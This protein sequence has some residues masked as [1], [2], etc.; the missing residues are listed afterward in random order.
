MV[1]RAAALALVVVPM[2]GGSAAN[3][4][5]GGAG[6][7]LTITTGG[8]T[9]DMAS[10]V[11]PSTH[12]PV[13]FMYAANGA[14]PSA[15]PGCSSSHGGEVTICDAS[16]LSS[17]VI[18][19]TGA[20]T[21]LSY[22]AYAGATPPPLTI[23]YAYPFSNFGVVASFTETPAGL[24]GP[25]NWAPGGPWGLVPAGTTVGAP[26]IINDETPLGAGLNINAGDG[27]AT[28][29]GGDAIGE[30]FT[31]GSGGGT[32]V[33]GSQP[34]TI[35]AQNHVVDHITCNS[36]QDIV[37]ADPEDVI[38][39]T[40]GTLDTGGPP[41]AAITASDSAPLTG[42]NVTF[43]ASGSSDRA[44]TITDYKWDFDG[45]GYH[46][47]TGTTATAPHTY[48]TPGDYTASVKI[49]D[50]GGDTAVRTMTVHVTP[51]PPTGT[52]GVS[53]DNGLI[54]TSDQSV[55]LGLVWPAGATAA[56]ISND[57]GFGPAGSTE[58]VT[59]TP[60]IPWTLESSGPERLPKTV[61]VRFLGA[62]SDQT[63]YTDDIVLDQTVPLVDSAKLTHGQGSQGQ[64]GMLV[65]TPSA[66]L[67]ARDVISGAT[68]AQ[69]SQGQQV[70]LSARDLISGVTTVQVA[71][72]NSVASTELVAPN[73]LGEYTVNQAIPV[74]LAAPKMV[75][76]RNAAGTWSEWTTLSPSNTVR[77]IV[78]RLKGKTLGRAKT[79]LRRAHCA[80]GVVYEPGQA[81][82]V[83]KV[84]T[85]SPRPG[86]R[87]PAGH[88]VSLTLT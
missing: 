73:T 35:R 64:Q 32:I 9:L 62:G 46:T 3:A 63:P 53:I 70:Q 80:L 42:Q 23:N 2:I 75:R 87:F 79:L 28:I 57:G 18:D 15:G 81:H 59:L 82:N 61:Y 40:C 60:T 74:G 44:R 86:R 76:V 20:P 41:S 7:T 17:I 54:A 36:N 19:N 5:I 48:T 39:G 38:T 84:K 66:Q 58:T 11:D 51:A 22:T 21:Q 71:N 85:Q 16:A 6:G 30:D 14:G 43:D 37:Y 29:N 27:Q 77:C 65:A 72:G 83:L 12:S 8:G 69:V 34:A 68:H 4:S 56:M 47:D 45:S 1:A 24:P 26:F 10:Y 78:P 31:L 33:T 49:T 50:N 25:W 13:F 55:T 67:S 88:R 52:V